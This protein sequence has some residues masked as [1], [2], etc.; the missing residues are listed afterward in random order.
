MNDVKFFNCSSS[1]L[2]SKWRGESE[3]LVKELFEMARHYAPSIIF[4][5]EVMMLP[6]KCTFAISRKVAFAI[7]HFQVPYCIAHMVLSLA[8]SNIMFEEDSVPC[9]LCARHNG[10]IQGDSEECMADRC[11]SCAC[12]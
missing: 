4:F 3:K 10:S 9:Y 6:E 2:M 5:D 8:M 7:F 11:L 1:T 12:C